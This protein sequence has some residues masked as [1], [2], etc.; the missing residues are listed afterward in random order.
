MIELVRTHD[1]VFLSW[2]EHQLAS[3]GIDACVLDDHTSSAYAGALDAVARRVMVAE[4]DL[5][6]AR[7]VLA[8]A[9]MRAGDG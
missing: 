9:G 8:E 4:T 3:A 5:G 6:R 2:L 1:P 7:L